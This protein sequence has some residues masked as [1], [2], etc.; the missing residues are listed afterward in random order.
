MHAISHPVHVG[1]LMQ[2]FKQALAELDSA[3]EPSE[4]SPSPAPEQHRYNVD[5]LSAAR[6]LGHF[7]MG[8]GKR[9][10]VFNR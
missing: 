9:V 1:G 2:G 5:G 10:K 4:R 8:R 7:P 6:L 3:R